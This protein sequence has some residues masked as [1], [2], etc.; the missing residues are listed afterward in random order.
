MGQTI[1]VNLIKRS[2]L[3][4]SIEVDLPTLN[5]D[6]VIPDGC[7]VIRIINNK[8]DDRIVWK[9]TSIPEIN[10]AKDAFDKLV[11]K[12]LVPYKV[13]TDGKAT[14][15]VMKEFDP[16]AEEVIFLPVQM[17]AGG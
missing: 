10:Q 4:D 7:G 12:G 15:E 14:S 6:E 8:G 9:K 3:V 5:V 16:S 13:G 1:E 2:K 11:A 17:I